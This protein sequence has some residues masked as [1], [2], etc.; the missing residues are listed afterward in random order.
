M[1]NL[2]ETEEYNT[3]EELQAGKS[4]WNKWLKNM[5]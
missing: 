2:H 3:I 4:V 1:D 5:E